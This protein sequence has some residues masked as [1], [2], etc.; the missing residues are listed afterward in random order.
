MP[1]KNGRGGKQ[2]AKQPR[3]QAGKQSKGK[4]PAGKHPR[5]QLPAKNPKVKAKVKGRIK[6]K[7]PP[8]KKQQQDEDGDYSKKRRYKPGSRYYCFETL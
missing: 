2:A 5:K 7:R 4:Q 8:L 3:N 6:G 1:P